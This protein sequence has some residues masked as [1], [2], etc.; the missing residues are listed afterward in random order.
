MS[1]A[2]DIVFLL[3]VNHVWTKARIRDIRATGSRLREIVL[4]DM[5]GGFPQ[6]G[7]QPGAVHL[8][9]TWRG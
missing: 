5:P 3:T 2:P 7:F 4:L 8:Q 1:L 9:R 6:S